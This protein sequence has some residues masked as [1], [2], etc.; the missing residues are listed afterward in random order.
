MRIFPK[1]YRLLKKQG[2]KGARSIARRFSRKRK[3]SVFTLFLK[4]NPL[5]HKS[6]LALAVLGAF[7]SAARREAINAIA[8]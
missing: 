5:G 8:F 3:G 7:L 1:R 4:K 6:N 2:E